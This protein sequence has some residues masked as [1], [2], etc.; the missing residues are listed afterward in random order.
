MEISCSMWFRHWL[1]GGPLWQRREKWDWAEG[2]GQQ[3][4]ATWGVHGAGT[5]CRQQQLEKSGQW[6]VHANTEALLKTHLQLK[7]SV[8]DYDV[9]ETIILLREL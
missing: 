3:R 5:P 7:G 4:R 1:P 9:V 8:F 2:G 6:G